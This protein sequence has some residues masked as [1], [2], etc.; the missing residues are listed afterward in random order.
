MLQNQTKIEGFMSE[1]KAKNTILFLKEQNKSL[2]KRNRFLRAKLKD[3]QK[4]R[5]A[6]KAKCLAQRAKQGDRTVEFDLF[7][8]IKAKHHSYS[9]FLVAF[10]ANMQAY[11]SM[12]LRACVH[13]LFCLQISF[14]AQKRLPSYTS[15]RNW[16]CKLGKYRI[17]NQAFSS[18]KWLYWLDESIHLGN[19]KI[20]LILGVP[21]KDLDFQRGVSLSQLRILHMEVSS[22]WTGEK[23]AAILEKLQK[24]FPL[25]YL[26]SDEG[27]NLQKSYSLS[28]CLHVP[29]CTHRLSKALERCY[30][31]QVLFKEFCHWAG[32]L[33]KKWSLSKGKKAYLPP[34]ERNKVR[35][36]NLFPLVAWAKNQVFSWETLPEEVRESFSFLKEHRDW[37]INFWKIQ[38]KLV[39]IS[40]ILKIEGYSL[41]N[42]S[43]IQGILGTSLA[44]EELLFSELVLAY[45]ATLS[46]KLGDREKLYCCSDVIESA[47]GKL[48]QK[49]SPNSHALS[50][51]IFSLACIG[52]Q[53]EVE[54]V[55]KALEKIKEKEIQKK[56]QKT[57]ERQANLSVF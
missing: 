11:G 36:A 17:E 38:E 41:S 1:D 44:A 57:E 19:E 42:A 3:T 15:I 46:E 32:D 54:E 10:C 26:I 24:Q 37:V 6:W 20:L 33:R 48:K 16:V 8:G 25:S 12:S 39:S 45:L 47:F 31:N 21:E 56:P 43:R 51:F 53:Y 30:K 7:A 34:N 29:D 9:L 49:L 14:S 28:H 13:V 5:E 27:N 50:S 18:E 55:Q 22:Q 2:K 23:I 35:F 40:L 4:S 52:G